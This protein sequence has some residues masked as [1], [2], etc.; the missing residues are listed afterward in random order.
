MTRLWIGLFLCVLSAQASVLSEADSLF[1][2][3]QY[4]QVEL[5][6]LRAERQQDI[7]SDEQVKLELL[8]GYA[9]IMLSREGDARAHFGQ[10]LDLDSTLALDPVEVSPKFKVVFDDLKQSWLAARAAQAETPKMVDEAMPVVSHS[11]SP[12]SVRSNFIIPGSGFLREGKTGRGLVHLGLTAVCAGLW[13]SEL[14]QNNTARKDYLAAST[15]DE[16]E[17]LYDEYNSHHGRMWAFGL[18]TVG[19]YALSQLDLA[20]WK[21]K[22]QLSANPAAATLELA[23]Q[24]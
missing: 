14:T 13:L 9:L 21:S 22:V 24:F 18:A 1:H 23:I 17:R 10:A 6:A 16:A 12:S 2:A 5:L 4:E 15:T 7:S 3:G 8:S 20:V 11:A 19:V